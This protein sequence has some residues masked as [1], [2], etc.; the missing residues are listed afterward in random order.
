MPEALIKNLKIGEWSPDDRPRERLL[1]KGKSEMSDA[2]L[3]SILL[4][5]GTE[6]INALEMAKQLLLKVSNNLFNLSRC[7]PAELM[8]QKG[9]GKAKALTI[10]AGLELGRRA[11]ESDAVELPKISCSKDAFE[12]I[13][14]ELADLRH[15]E[16]WVLLLN[17][18]NNLIRKR[19]ISSGGVTGTV[20]DPKLIYRYALE[21]LACGIV[22]AHNHP[23]GNLVASKQDIVLTDK[24]KHAGKL[25]EIQ[26]ID[27]LIVSGN[28]YYS[29]ADQGRI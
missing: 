18:A 1:E 13:Y 2:E 27:H 3:L 11:R 23:S 12:L 17:R 24:L 16:F 20:A 21:S 14:N 4:G 26:L 6:D 25:L 19:K 9:I 22:V 15:E 10:V 29:F 5:T 28:K 8:E 7:N